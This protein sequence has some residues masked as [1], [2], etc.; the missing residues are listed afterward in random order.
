M[1]TPSESVL[2]PLTFEQAVAVYQLLL[3]AELSDAEKKV[4]VPVLSHLKEQIRESREPER[5]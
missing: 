3:F 1:T 5:R 2:L 4:L